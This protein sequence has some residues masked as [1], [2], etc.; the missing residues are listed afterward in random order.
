MNKIKV[1]PELAVMTDDMDRKTRIP[2]STPSHHQPNIQVCSIS[3]PVYNLTLT[4]QQILLLLTA[5]MLVV[6]S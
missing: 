5:K 3:Y 6:K 4:T 2:T 1:S